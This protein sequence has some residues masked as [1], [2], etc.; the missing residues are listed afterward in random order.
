MPSPAQLSTWLHI[1]SPHPPALS[2]SFSLFHNKENPNPQTHTYTQ[3]SEKESVSCSAMSYFLRPQGLVAHQTPLSMEFS[4]QKYWSGLPLP[5]S[6]ALPESGIEPGSPALQADSLLSAPPG[7]PLHTQS[8]NICRN[9]FKRKRK[10]E[11]RLCCD[12]CSEI[13]TC[14]VWVSA[15]GWPPSWSHPLL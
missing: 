4:R 6:G 10:N 8:A 1:T 14:W 3:K 9:D 12:K 7:K 5:F 11:D 15:Q 13:Y 2:S